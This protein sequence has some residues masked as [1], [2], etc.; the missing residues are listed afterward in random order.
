MNITK[1]SIIY[2]LPIIPAFKR[3]FYSIKFEI[4]VMKIV[5]YIYVSLIFFWY[6]KNKYGFFNQQKYWIQWKISKLLVCDTFK[7]VTNN[8]SKH[9]DFRQ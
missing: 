1:I 4:S 9:I 3:Y 5:E 8:F 7:M 6:N 2:S